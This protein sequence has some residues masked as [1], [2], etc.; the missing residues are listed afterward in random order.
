MILYLNSMGMQKMDLNNNNVD[1]RVEYF[2]A[3]IQAISPIVLFL[4]SMTC[5]GIIIVVP[6]IDSEAKGLLKTTHG[7]LLTSG[8]ALLGTGKRREK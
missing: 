1:D 4:A 2:S 7:T 3:L 6:S 5:L 8:L